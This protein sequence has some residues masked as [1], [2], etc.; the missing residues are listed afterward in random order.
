MTAFDSAMPNPSWALPRDAWSQTSVGMVATP[1]ER[2]LSVRSDTAMGDLIR[3]TR[4]NAG[5]RVLVVEDD[6]LVGIVAPSDI[7]RW[8]SVYEVVGGAAE[9]GSA[10]RR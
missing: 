5:D 8:V 2:L 9:S 10:I 7:A 1:R 6:R 3:T 4:L